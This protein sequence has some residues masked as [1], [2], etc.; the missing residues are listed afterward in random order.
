MP[1]S[2]EQ[3]IDQIFPKSRTTIDEVVYS[4]ACIL[5]SY[6]AGKNEQ[7][8][9]TFEIVKGIS[10]FQALERWEDHEKDIYLISVKESDILSWRV[11]KQRQVERRGTIDDARQLSAP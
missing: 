5:P 7:Q 6:S 11:L 8:G 3:V 10:W 1:P 2:P 4:F 9:E